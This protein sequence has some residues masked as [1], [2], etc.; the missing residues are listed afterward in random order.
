MATI[1]GRRLSGQLRS[2]A[3]P[4]VPTF[5]AKDPESLRGK[6]ARDRHK[7]ELASFEREFAPSILDLAGVRIM[8]YRPADEDPTCD[9]LG[10]LLRC[11]RANDSRAITPSRVVIAL[12]IAS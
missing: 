5:R 10:A 1:V 9:V 2:A 7:H 6:L 4:H 3:I 11:R 8:L 12:A